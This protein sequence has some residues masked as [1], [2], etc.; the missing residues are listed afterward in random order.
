M[1]NST[2]RPAAG[3]AAPGGGRFLQLDDHQ[4][5][6]HNICVPDKVFLPG[7]TIQFDAGYIPC[8]SAFFAADHPE[9][10]AAL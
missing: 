9:L 5:T 6:L 3:G 4:P 2:N 8:C 10:F 7:F 1:A